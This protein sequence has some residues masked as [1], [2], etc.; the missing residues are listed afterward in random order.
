MAF[1][2]LSALDESVAKLNN[3]GRQR[4]NN[5]EN[6]TYERSTWSAFGN[7]A[8]NR[9][10]NNNGN[11]NRGGG[12]NFS[13]GG[14]TAKQFNF[15]AGNPI[16]Q[17]NDQKN[18]NNQRRD[19]RMQLDVAK[20]QD[21]V[22]AFIENKSNTNELYNLIGRDFMDIAKLITSRYFDI[23]Y[24]DAVQDMNKVLTLFTTQ[25]A[26]ISLGNS[27]REG[28]FGDLD[29]VEKATVGAFI[30]LLL[31]TCESQMVDK[32]IVMYV[33]IVSE[34]LYPTQV[35]EM[36]STLGISEEAAI[37]MIIAVPYFG[38]TMTGSQLAAYAPK[39]LSVLI[40]Y[41]EEMINTMTAE[42]QKDW[43]YFVFPD[44]N[45]QSIKV[46]G[47]CLAEELITFTDD[48]HIALYNEYVKMLYMVLHDNDICDIT[49]SLKFIVKEIARRNT[50]HKNDPIIFSA[51]YAADCSENIKKALIEL[52]TKDA[53]AKKAFVE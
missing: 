20:L 46:A 10:N 47:R 40:D 24:S 42:N 51:K 29:E 48:K 15:K 49:M 50:L 12:F 3:N 27:I 16:P 22:A 6:G 19:T 9:R 2:D 35:K 5:N 26:A 44:I 4:N 32:T 30:S 13:N 18:N 23:K 53:E 17:K 39:F 28:V 34:V 45:H 25:V 36:S 37:D 7:N 38:R 14:F 33:D 1:L 41:S 43:F 52:C 31:D 8:N 21:F 11:N